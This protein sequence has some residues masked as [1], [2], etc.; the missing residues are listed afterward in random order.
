MPAMETRGNNAEHEANFP[1][2]FQTMKMMP[3]TVAAKEYTFFAGFDFIDEKNVGMVNS[4]VFIFTKTIG[5]T[6]FNP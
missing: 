1:I 4:F 2:R 5:K 6:K 3:A